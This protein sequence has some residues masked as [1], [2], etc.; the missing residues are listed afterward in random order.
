MPDEETVPEPSDNETPPKDTGGEQ[1]ANIIPERI[2]ESLFITEIKNND[3]EA[4]ES[5]EKPQ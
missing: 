3:N 2:T 1:E 4:T 5:K